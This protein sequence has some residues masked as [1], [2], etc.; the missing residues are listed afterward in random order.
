MRHGYFMEMFRTVGSL[1]PGSNWNGRVVLQGRSHLLCRIK[2]H[3]P[4]PPPSSQEDAYVH[5]A[6]GWDGEQDSDSPVCPCRRRGSG[7]PGMLTGFSNL[8]SIVNLK[9]MH[10]LRVANFAWGKMRTT[11]WETAL[12][13]SLRNCSKEVEEES[14]YIWL[15]WRGSSVQSSTYFT[16]GVLLVTGSWCH[17]KGI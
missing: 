15:Q 12:Q 10:K 11:T 5:K 1:P 7:S 2:N 13:V 3:L 6:I 16:E 17:L 8:E 14:Q 9:K 4:L